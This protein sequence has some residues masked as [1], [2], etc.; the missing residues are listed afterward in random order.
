MLKKIISI[1]LVAVL[2]FSMCATVMAVN[3]DAKNDREPSVYGYIWVDL[4]TNARGTLV[5][6]YH[7]HSWHEHLDTCSF[8]G[9]KWVGTKYYIVF[10]GYGMDYI[11]WWSGPIYWPPLVS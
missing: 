10:Y 3:K 8:E 5:D 7:S 6:P 1:L 4:I 2:A 11:D 9:R